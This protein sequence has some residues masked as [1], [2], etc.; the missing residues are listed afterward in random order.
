[1]PVGPLAVDRR[2][3]QKKLINFFSYIR[4]ELKR[5]FH[6]VEIEDRKS[7]LTRIE[8]HPVVNEAKN[9]IKRMSDLDPENPGV[10]KVN[11]VKTAKSF[12]RWVQEKGARYELSKKHNGV[13]RKIVKTTEQIADLVS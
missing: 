7:G 8:Q 6:P 11:S 13:W 9:W 1:M 3:Q 2:N 4:D 10:Y 12:V 5:V